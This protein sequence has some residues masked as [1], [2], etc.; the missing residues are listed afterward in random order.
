MQGASMTAVLVAMPAPRTASHDLLRLTTRVA[1]MYHER[2][3]G[4][5]RIAE[6]LGLSQA[7]V[8]RL[9]KQAE[10]LG[11]VRI[12][13]HVPEGVHAEIEEQLEG[14]YALDE[15]IVVETPDAA[16]N[17]DEL[18]NQALSS[19]VASY[20]ELMVPTLKTIGVSSWSSA[21]LAAV[22][23][24]RP[25]GPGETQSI[26]QVLG[27]VGF[28]N[29]QRFATRL[30]ERLAQLSKAD[31][32]FMLA[33]GVVT[34]LAAKA[35]LLTDPSV[36]QALGRFDQLSALL[37]GIGAIPPSRMLRESGNVFTDQ[38]LADLRAAGAVG[39]VCM[40]FYDAHGRHVATPFDE[41]VLGIGVEQIRRI[42]RR[43]GVAGGARK[44]EA[45]RA[46]LRGGWISTLVT[47]LTTAQ[48]LLAEP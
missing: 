35:A 10:K 43:I 44:F 6:Q 23:A 41:R 40:R 27:G 13:V 14:R 38:D 4:Q 12:T 8:S 45:I 16:L 39:D 18:M 20:L 9:L 33:P 24:M 19:T 29:A 1:S 37:M 42:R 34:S 32:I 47:D 30:T 48:R 2:G 22:N 36:G 17:D 25:T 28:A 15:L 11:I 7:R 5:T 3:L 31:A 46:A 26:V 21:L